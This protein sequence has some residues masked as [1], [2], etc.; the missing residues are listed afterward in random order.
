MIREV[1]IMLNRNLVKLSA[2]LLILLCS[3]TVFSGSFSLSPWEEALVYESLWNQYSLQEAY[4]QGLLSQEDLRIINLYRADHKSDVTVDNSVY[5]ERLRERQK[6]YG[7]NEELDSETAKQ[8]KNTFFKNYVVN[9][10]DSEIN[11]WNEDTLKYAE[12]V[13]DGQYAW[14]NIE[15]QNED[16]FNNYLENAGYPLTREKA[17]KKVYECIYVYA[18]IGVFSDAIVVEMHQRFPY[19]I[20]NTMIPITFVEVGGIVVKSF[21]PIYVFAK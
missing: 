21:E 3:V 11:R 7:S 19:F 6:Y 9:E 20:Y 16:D 1:K 14:L 12:D 17:Y 18:Y 10:L 13:R 15:F 8:I 5:E 2:V 4:D